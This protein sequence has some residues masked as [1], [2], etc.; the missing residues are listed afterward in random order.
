MKPTN[1]TSKDIS[2]RAK[3]HFQAALAAFGT[4]YESTTGCACCVSRESGVWHLSVSH[5]KRLPTWDEM[6]SARE[7]FTP[8]DVTM[9]VL[10]PP[11]AEYVN[12]HETCMHMYQIFPE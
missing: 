4:W 12:M 8:D 5:P 3:P 7:R 6:R 10:L 2:W 1:T 9:A 11:S